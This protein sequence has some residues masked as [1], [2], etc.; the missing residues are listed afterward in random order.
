M[1]NRDRDR[2]REKGD[3]C[4]GVRLT[5]ARAA[6]QSERK[7]SSTLSKQ[8]IRSTLTFCKARYD[9]NFWGIP[10]YPFHSILVYYI[11]VLYYGPLVSLPPG[12]FRNAVIFSGLTSNATCDMRCD[13]D[14]P[15]QVLPF[16]LLGLGVDDSFVICNAFGRTDPRKSLPERMKEGLGTSGQSLPVT[17]RV[18][19]VWNRQRTNHFVSTPF[20][21]IH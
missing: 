14:Q 10:L 15:F 11:M 13:G 17:R 5:P 4:G 19:H 3:T 2:D 18:T 6:S 21:D 7:T 12:V 8:P 16:I 1:K 9:L 20:G